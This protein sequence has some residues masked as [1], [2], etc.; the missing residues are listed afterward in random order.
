[1]CYD[2]GKLYVLF[3]NEVTV[4]YTLYVTDGNGD[5]LASM[6]LEGHAYEACVDARDHRIYIPMGSSG[7]LVVYL[8]GNKLVTEKT[9]TCVSS[10]V[11]VGLTSSDSMYVCNVPKKAVYLVDNS[12]D[13]IVGELFSP[14]GTPYH[15]AAIRD[16]VLVHYQGN[17]LVLYEHGIS[18]TGKTLHECRVSVRVINTDGIHFLLPLGTDI[19]SVDVEGI[20]SMKDFQQYASY[21][22]VTGQQL[23][24]FDWLFNANQIDLPPIGNNLKV[25]TREYV[26]S[27]FGSILQ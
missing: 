27:I 24:A 5:I 21:C 14:Y 10:A 12:L 16:A 22:V 25:V 1:M 3:F 23:W 19:I 13:K 17:V 11:S 26:G 20:L 2:E 8:D 18:A 15:V 4:S 7:V 6:R 9:I